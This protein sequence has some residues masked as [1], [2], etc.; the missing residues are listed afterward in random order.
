MYVD[1]IIVTG[2]AISGVHQ[3]ISR[4]S[5]RFSLKDLGPLNYFLGVQVLPRE[6][7]LVL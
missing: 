5:Q 3:I 1:D 7:G 2:N 4:L 6:K